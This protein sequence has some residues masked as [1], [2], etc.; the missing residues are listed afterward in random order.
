[1]RSV[2]AAL[3]IAQLTVHDT[4]AAQAAGWSVQRDFQI[5]TGG[6]HPWFDYPDTYIASLEAAGNFFLGNE[7]IRVHAQSKK[8]TGGPQATIRLNGTADVYLMVDDRWSTTT[9]K[10]SPPPSWLAGWSN[11]GF[12]MVVF[13]IPGSQMRPFSIFR[14][15]GQTGDVTTPPIGATTAFNYFI[16]VD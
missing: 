1:V 2:C 7:W 9:P 10:F 8:F 15:T 3:K 16:I 6:A 5:G 14:K 13:E 4:D 12:K 11:A